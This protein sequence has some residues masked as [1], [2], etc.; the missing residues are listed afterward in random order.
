MRLF[1]GPGPF[2]VRSVNTA[3]SPLFLIAIFE[4]VAT[5]PG[6]TYDT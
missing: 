1:K 5:L 2:A 6:L 4:T 3:H